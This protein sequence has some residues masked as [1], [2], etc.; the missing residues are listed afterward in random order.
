MCCHALGRFGSAI[1]SGNFTGCRDWTPPYPYPFPLFRNK[2]R[3]IS[4]PCGS[5][6]FDVVVVVAVVVV[7]V[8]AVVADVVVVVAAVVVVMV[9]AVDVAVVVASS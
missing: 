4:L 8:A 7:V 1:I 9:V 5:I 6:V 3:N 2:K